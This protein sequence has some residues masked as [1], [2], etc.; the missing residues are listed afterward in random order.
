MTWILAAPETRRGAT[1]LIC[2][3]VEINVMDVLYCVA[4]GCN[5]I[6]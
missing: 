2:L 5:A 1:Q 6:R 3:D 4:F